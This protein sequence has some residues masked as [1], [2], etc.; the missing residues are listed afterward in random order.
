MKI[1]L[2]A[3][4]GDF[5]PDCTVKGA[6]LASQEIPDDIKIVL[7][8]N[9]DIIQS[10]LREHNINNPSIEVFHADDVIEMGEHPTKALSQ[11]PKA[12]IPV[13]Y[14]L[15]KSGAVKAFCSAGNTG[16]MH[17]G[18][19]F[20]IKAIEGIIRPGIAGF[21]PK[22]SGDFGVIMDVG[23]NADCK[24]DV[25]YQFGEMGSLYAK[26]VFNMQ[27]PKVGLMNLG[28][29]EQKGTLL[30]Q[31]AY[32]LFKIS[33]RINFVGNIEG[34]DLF[35]DKADVIVCDGFTGNVIL[36]MAE[37][38]FD[39]L[40]KRNIKDDYFDRFNYEAI[41][42]SPILGINGNVVIGHGVSS[43]EAIKNM[44]LLSVKMAESNIHLKIKEH[45]GE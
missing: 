20:T 28:E 9:E 17:V 37:S 45:L 6:E 25:L 27:K 21:I 32:Q 40:Q 4:G 2:D 14:G 43:P 12:S 8:G 30:T 33:N 1:A 31:A 7:V 15:L 41:G 22:E 5:A 39:L 11:K 10:K 26:H 29:E 38:F 36:K 24:P 44:I 23:A 18:A 34:R 19:M 3:M 42:G 13:G 16:A 35:N